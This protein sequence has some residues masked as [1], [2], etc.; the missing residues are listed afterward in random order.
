MTT[1]LTRWMSAL[2]LTALAWLAL[3]ALVTRFSDAAPLVLVVLPDDAFLAHLPPEMAIVSRSR[4]SITL[5]SDAP[6]IAGRL[7]AAGAMLVLPAG[8]K[9]CLGLPQT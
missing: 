7:Y 3:V 4:L 1:S 6:D 5:R 8:L 2:A 9:G